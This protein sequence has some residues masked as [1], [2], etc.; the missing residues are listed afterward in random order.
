MTQQR[1]DFEHRLGQ[2]LK[3]WAESGKPSLDLDAYVR[4]KTDGEAEVP[5]PVAVPPRR[6][7]WRGWLAGVAA[8]AAVV[9]GMFATFPSWAGAATGIPIV[10]PVVKE[11]ILKDAGLTWAYDVGVLQGTMA[12][13]TDGEVSAR[14]LGVMADQFRTT[15]IYQI[16]G[17]EK[18]SDR[19][20]VIN[21]S[22]G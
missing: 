17:V 8:A 5:V 14:I 16:T 3:R 7:S 18:P 20:E 2:G 12:E 9:L 13:A 6:R 4:S 15:I 1:D 11:I 22:D 10:G 19:G 21:I